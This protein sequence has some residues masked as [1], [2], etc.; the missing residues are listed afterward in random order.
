MEIGEAL[1]K[2]KTSR[3]VEL[4]EGVA[5]EKGACSAAL[6]CLSEVGKAMPRGSAPFD[7]TR[8]RDFQKVSCVVLESVS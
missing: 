5:L 1:S 8:A 4:L 7:T 2:K 3:T 6:V